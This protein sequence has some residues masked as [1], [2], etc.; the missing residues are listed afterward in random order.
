MFVDRPGDLARIE[1]NV[2][3]NAPTRKAAK[4]NKTTPEKDGVKGAEGVVYKVAS[5]R[6]VSISVFICDH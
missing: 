3:A 1:E 2:S 4:S 6:R 5:S